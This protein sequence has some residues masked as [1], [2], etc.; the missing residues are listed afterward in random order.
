MLGSAKL[1]PLVF[2]YFYYNF[3]SVKEI[4]DFFCMNSKVFGVGEFKYD[5]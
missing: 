2:L 1:G 4:G 5:I 3:N